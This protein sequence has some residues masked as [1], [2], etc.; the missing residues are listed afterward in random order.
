VTHFSLENVFAAGDADKLS[1]VNGWRKLPHIDA[2]VQRLFDYPQQFAEDIFGRIEQ[3]LRHRIAG[4]EAHAAVQ[5]GRLF[6]LSGDAP[7]PDSKLSQIADLPARYIGSS[8]R[9]Q[10][11]RDRQEG[12]F[13]VSYETP[14]GWVAMTKDVLTDVLG[15]GRDVKIVGLP[16]LAAAVLQRMCPDLVI[17]S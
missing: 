3:A 14:D 17:R 2:Q 7:G 9:T 11:L 15:A 1:W 6:I 4:G 12:M 8:E 10:L 5:T 16:G 13:L